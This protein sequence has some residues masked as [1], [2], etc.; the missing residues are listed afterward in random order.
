LDK[1]RLNGQQISY[2]WTDNR[3]TL[4]SLSIIV[5]QGTIMKQ[6]QTYRTCDTAA[7]WSC[8]LLNAVMTCVIQLLLETIRQYSNHRQS[9]QP[10]RR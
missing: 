7:D 8:C 5:G 1:I 2:G 9:P 10:S 3:K 6:K 4:C